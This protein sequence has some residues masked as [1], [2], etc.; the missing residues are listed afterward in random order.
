MAEIISGDGYSVAQEPMPVSGYNLLFEVNEGEQSARMALRCGGI[1]AE[2]VDAA[3]TN[4]TYD[5]P[6]LSEQI[7]ALKTACDAYLAEDVT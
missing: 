5:A 3:I 7:T 4:L 6:Q 2:I 1:T